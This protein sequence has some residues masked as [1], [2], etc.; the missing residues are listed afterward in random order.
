MHGEGGEGS[1]QFIKVT[2]VAGGFFAGCRVV[3]WTGLIISAPAIIWVICR[4]VF[5]GLTVREKQ[6]V[7][8]G[9]G[10][11]AILFA[12]GV[13]LGYFTTMPIAL[14]MMFA[15]NRLLGVTCEWVELPDYIGF[16]L[17][18]LL[19]FGLAFE[20][21]V[22][23]LALGSVGIVTS[24]QLRDKHRH[25]IVGLMVMAMLLTPQDPLTML[26]MALPLIALYE[27]CIWWIYFGERGRRGQK[28][29][30]GGGKG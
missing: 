16:V 6:A 8:R 17:K 19:A 12:G 3:L 21:P 26:L 5:P 13:A 23:V 22:I 15:V 2:T 20:L 30:E 7:L 29:A 1:H 25:V 4:F 9:S 10:F 11:A 27:L 28:G 18:L 24:E 14:E